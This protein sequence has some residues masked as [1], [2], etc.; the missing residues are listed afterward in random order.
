MGQPLVPGLGLKPEGA[1]PKGAPN[2]D[3]GLVG[4]VRLGAQAFAMVLLHRAQEPS[5]LGRWLARSADR[6]RKPCVCRLPSV[7]WHRNTRTGS[8]GWDGGI[9]GRGPDRT[10]ERYRDTRRIQIVYPA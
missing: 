7:R 10:P 6:P 5:S 1:L 9:G 3:R 8:S 2:S 4:V